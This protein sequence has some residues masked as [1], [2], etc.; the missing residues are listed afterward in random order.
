MRSV[1]DGAFA[2]ATKCISDRRTPTQPGVKR[3]PTQKR[4]WL[5]AQKQRGAFDRDEFRNC[6]R[7]RESRR[8][9]FLLPLLSSRVELR[10]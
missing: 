3:K 10:L 9:S 5:E 1:I 8:E 7:P 6:Y 4:R 2:K